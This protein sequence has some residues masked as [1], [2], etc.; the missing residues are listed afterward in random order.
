MRLLIV[1]PLALLPLATASAAP[2]PEVLLTPPPHC[3][4]NGGPRIAELDT[5]RPRSQR[6]GELPP[7]RL[8]LAVMRSMGGCP[9]PVTLR[10]GYGSGATQRPVTRPEPPRPPSSRLIRR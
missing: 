7:G 3:A 8:D 6:L 10:E 4:S 9:E 1:L 5:P 2:A